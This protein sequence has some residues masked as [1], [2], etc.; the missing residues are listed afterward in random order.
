MAKFTESVIEDATLDWLAGLGY[1][2]KHGPEIAP[3][4]MS[5]ERR[6]F[7]RAVLDHRLGD[8]LARLNPAP[9]AEVLAH[10]FRGQTWGCLRPGVVR[11]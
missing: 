10:A 8:T 7:R 9:P 5:A 11:T 6:D 3:G 4:G 1:V 2:V